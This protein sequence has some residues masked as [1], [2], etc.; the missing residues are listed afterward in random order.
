MLLVLAYYLRIFDVA[1]HLYAG[2][3]V[4]VGSSVLMDCGNVWG[5]LEGFLR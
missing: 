5:R 4:I 3:E 2:V 1:A